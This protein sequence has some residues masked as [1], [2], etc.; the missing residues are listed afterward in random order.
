VLGLAGGAGRTTGATAA[1]RPELVLD[2]ESEQRRGCRRLR[3][4]RRHPRSAAAGVLAVKYRTGRTAAGCRQP[5]ELAAAAPPRMA[6]CY[7]TIAEVMR[8]RHVELLQREE[9]RVE[10]AARGM[11]IS[12]GSVSNLSRLGLAC[13]EQLHEAAG[14]RLGERYRQEA[15]VLHLDGTREGGHWCHFVLRE[16]FT[17]N[18]LLARKV[19]SEHS[20]DIAA[21]LRRVAELFGPP[22]ALVSDMSAAI[23]KA[24]A[25]VFPGLRHL[26]CHFHFLRDVGTALLGPEHEALGHGL[27]HTRRELARLRREAVAALRAGDA[28]QRW[29]VALVDRTGQY[30]TELSAEGF[31]FDLPNLHC[32]RH[33]AT[34]LAETEAILAHL[35]IGPED[36]LYRRLVE[37]RA[38][39]RH[40]ADSSPF[41]RSAARLA[42]LDGL[43]RNLRDILHPRSTD[44]HEPLNWGRI[45]QPQ[46]LPDTAAALDALRERAR[47]KA[48]C[49]TLCPGDRKAWKTMP[50]HL[51]RYAGML[52]PILPVRGRTFLLPRTNNLSET[53]FGDLKRRQR[54]TTGNGDLGR[55]IDHLPPQVSYA[56]NLADPEYCRL[57]FGGRP[58]HEAFAAADWKAVRAAVAAMATPESPGAVDRKLVRSPT[59]FAIVGDALVKELGQYPRLP[60]KATALTP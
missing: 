21:M 2:L 53:A 45:G 32:A 60:P 19:R 43:F 51:A 12:A 37:F 33:C 59:F 16:G 9:V 40:T 4:Q 14:P 56:D 17:G 50:A 31:P 27:K 26:V 28:R 20:A 29:L 57:A 47:R 55:Q 54:R 3:Y 23:L 49:K 10:L 18:A 1:V 13:L 36:P 8:L 42:R 30:R 35:R 11:P 58:M 44:R 25:E 5:G 41:A 38:L 6:F 46:L 39:L 48:A 7:D 22:D 24:A 34:V 15:F 52:D